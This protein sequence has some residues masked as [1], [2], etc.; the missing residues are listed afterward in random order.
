MLS[1]SQAFFLHVMQHRRFPIGLL[2]QAGKYEKEGIP[3][4]WHET[5][6]RRGVFS[7]YRSHTEKQH[8]QGATEL[9]SLVFAL[10][11]VRFLIYQRF[12]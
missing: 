12:E 9:Y 3:V 8:L 10:L 2:W 6:K 4:A 11:R 5:L 7:V 1:H